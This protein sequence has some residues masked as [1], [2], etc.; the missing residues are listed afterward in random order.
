MKKIV[1][2][3]DYVPFGCLELLG[4]ETGLEF[5]KKKKDLYS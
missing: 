1:I 2:F 4:E 5:E 3:L